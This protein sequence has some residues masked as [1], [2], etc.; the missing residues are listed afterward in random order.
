MGGRLV[1]GLDG[2][3]PDR[4][5]EQV[6]VGHLV[7]R[8]TGGGELRVAE[9]LDGDTVEGVDELLDDRAGGGLVGGDAGGGRKS[10]ALEV[11]G[12][13]AHDLEASGGVLAVEG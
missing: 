2:L 12:E 13:V 6:L 5:S 10:T 7:D 11:E 3:T 8:D 1:E 4:D 9:P